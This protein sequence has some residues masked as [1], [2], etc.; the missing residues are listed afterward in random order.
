[1]NSYEKIYNL[2]TEMKVTVKKK[3]ASTRPTGAVFK[4]Q[5]KT[6]IKTADTEHGQRQGARRLKQAGM[7]L[8]YERLRSQGKAGPAVAAA[9]RKG[10]Y[11]P[12]KDYSKE[13][14]EIMK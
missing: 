5:A 9:Y 8:T 6:A 14:K 12:K 13:N 10:T 7:N 3:P 11:D 4:S 1:M 2:V